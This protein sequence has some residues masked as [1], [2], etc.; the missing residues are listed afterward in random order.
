[1]LTIAIEN[2]PPRL[3][4]RLALWLLEVRAGVYV[5]N[6]S[7]RMREYLWQ[8]VRGGIEDGSAIIIWSAPTEQGIDIDTIGETTRRVVGSQIRLIQYA[9]YSAQTREQLQTLEDEF[10]LADEP[11]PDGG[12]HGADPQIDDSTR[13]G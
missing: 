13:K 7:A 3:R 5:G 4:G 11:T 9:D 10:P 2:A 6:F 8:T 12:N 1:M